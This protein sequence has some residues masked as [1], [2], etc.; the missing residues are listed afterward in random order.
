MAEKRTLNSGQRYAEGHKTE[1]Q[2]AFN[3]TPWGG[4]LD[5]ERQ[6]MELRN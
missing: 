5:A 1:P 2:T 3:A 6:T 4:K